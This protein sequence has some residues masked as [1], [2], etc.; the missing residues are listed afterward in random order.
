LKNTTR[1]LDII[2]F[3]CPLFNFLLIFSTESSL[4]KS[5]VNKKKW[6]WQFRKARK[7]AEGSFHAYIDIFDRETA[8][9]NAEGAKSDT[10]ELN[11]SVDSGWCFV[12]ETDLTLASIAKPSSDPSSSESTEECK[13]RKTGAAKANVLCGY[14]NKCKVGSRGKRV[15]KRRWFVYADKS[16]KLLYYHTPQDTI[17]L[18]DID[19]AQAAFSF[20]VQ[21][22]V[23]TNVFRIT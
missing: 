16:F 7:M 10:L 18:G 23:S 17:S 11:D 2:L 4:R 3:S 14:L 21:P 20:D 12:A 15:F 13:M 19:I 9:E 6:V 1:R 5:G 22:N 8:T